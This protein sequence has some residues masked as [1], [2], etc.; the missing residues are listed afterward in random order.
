MKNMMKQ[1]YKAV[2]LVS[3]YIIAAELVYITLMVK[4]VNNPFLTILVAFA[5]LALG[6]LLGFFYVKSE[7][8]NHLAKNNRIIQDEAFKYQEENTDLDNE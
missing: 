5:I 7:Y 8:K 6:S 4:L 2:L 3:G 1:E